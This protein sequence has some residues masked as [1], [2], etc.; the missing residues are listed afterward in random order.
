MQSKEV[1]MFL[2]RLMAM[3]LAVVMTVSCIPCS[4]AQNAPAAP[5][6]QS[7]PD[8]GAVAGAV[9]SDTIYIPGK[10]STCALGGVFWFLAMVVTAGTCYK[11]C[12]NFVHDACTGKW[13]VKGEDM[14]SSK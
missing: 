12:G 4:W 5:P 11:D 1:S 10:A 2:N 13:V 14:V 7:S 8:G 9:V 6:E 3:V